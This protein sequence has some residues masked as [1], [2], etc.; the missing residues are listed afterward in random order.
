MNK[1]KSIFKPKKLSRQLRKYYRWMRL[2]LI[3]VRQTEEELGSE[4][5]PC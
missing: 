3:R 2:Y 1:E 5:Q 4:L